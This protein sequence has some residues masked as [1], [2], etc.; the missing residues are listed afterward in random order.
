MSAFIQGIDIFVQSDSQGPRDLTDILKEAERTENFTLE[1]VVPDSNRL[2]KC[3]FTHRGE[4][5]PPSKI[6]W[7]LLHRVSDLGVEVVRTE[8]IYKDADRSRVAL[9]S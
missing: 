9:R 3:R 1:E 2:C 6:I 8:N 5:R 7:Q 4:G